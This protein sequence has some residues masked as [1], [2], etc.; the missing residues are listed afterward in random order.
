M[1]RAR[2]AVALL[3]LH[4]CIDQGARSPSL[5]S[6]DMC[7]QVSDEGV[8]LCAPGQACIDGSCYDCSVEGWCNAVSC[9][10]DGD[11]CTLQVIGPDSGAC[12]TLLN[13]DC[14][15][16]VTALARTF[17]GAQAYYS[18]WRPSGDGIGPPELS[19][20]EQ[21]PLLQG[22]TPSPGTC[23]PAFGGPDSNGDHL[24][25]VDA[26]LWQ[27]ETWRFLGFKLEEGHRF[28]YSF[29][30]FGD[31]S[32]EPLF[33]ILAV[34]DLDCDGTSVTFSLQGSFAPDSKPYFDSWEL[35]RLNKP[36]QIAV[37]HKALANGPAF[38]DPY[39]DVPPAT[40]A[41]DAYQIGVGETYYG[42]FSEPLVYLQEM[43]VG[44]MRYFS[45]PR[46]QLGHK[47]WCL[48]APGDYEL[49]KPYKAHFPEYLPLTYGLTPVEGTCCSSRGG[50]DTKSD[51]FCDSN[52]GSFEYGPW[53]NLGFSVDSQHEFVYAIEEDEWFDVTRLRFKAY[54]DPDCDGQYEMLVLTATIP[55]EPN[56]CSVSQE[57]FLSYFPVHDW[58]PGSH[59]GY[60]QAA[61]IPVNYAWLGPNNLPV[62]IMED[63]LPGDES[64]EYLFHEPLVALQAIVDGTTAYFDDN[65]D[66][67]EM[68]P[69]TPPLGCCSWRSGTADSDGDNVCDPELVDWSHE[70]W[71][72]IG[73]SISVE[74]SYWYQV[75]SEIL[76]DGNRLIRATAM[77][78][79]DC[80]HRFRTIER[81]GIAQQTPG[82]CS[83]QWLEGYHI[84]NLFE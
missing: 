7:P 77:G 25:D 63:D 44:A 75:T 14:I 69:L 56:V 83:I 3:L 57:Q 62:E 6:D 23:C 78:D 38:I 18:M 40:T 82:E 45:I 64:F 1:I 31:S 49:M 65:C 5:D 2:A 59:P 61:G 50:H 34:G 24:C 17:R 15:E 10:D 71:L 74:H 39:L 28:A 22:M 35:N 8:C 47:P 9:E 13:P 21:M 72:A 54:R 73:F 11:P 32:G 26:S 16:P 20:G 76:D 27:T 60:Q 84:E 33:E 42:R 19:F 51:D 67:P 52:I 30:E 53:S 55:D 68:P 46:A 43:Y 70:F 36:T 48:S 41:N 79:P 4:S 29:E 81:F 80:N 37:A 12:A 58:A 66:L